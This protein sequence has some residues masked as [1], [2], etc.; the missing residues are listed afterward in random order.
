MRNYECLDD[1]D[2]TPAHAYFL[3]MCQDRGLPEEAAV[4][5]FNF[6]VRGYQ[7]GRFTYAL[8]S[9]LAEYDPELEGFGCLGEPGF[10]NCVGVFDELE[11]QHHEDRLYGRE[12]MLDQYFSYC[13]EQGWSPR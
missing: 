6:G 3:L 10:V 9:G 7:D 4:D 1:L 2:L 11:A 12:E 5:L 8:E 13:R